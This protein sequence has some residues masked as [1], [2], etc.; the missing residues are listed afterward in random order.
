MEPLFYPLYAP[1]EWSEAAARETIR[2]WSEIFGPRKPEA[3]VSG[4]NLFQEGTRPKEVF[5]LVEGLILLTCTAPAID[6]ECILGVRFPGQVVEQCAHNLDIPYPVSAVA[7]VNSQILR[8]S[9]PALRKRE[10]ENSSTAAFFERLLSLDLYNAVLFIMELKRSLPA[11]RLKHFLNLL[12]SVMG[13]ESK[14]GKLQIAMPLHDNQI[15]NIL[16]F[17]PRQFK[18]V[19]RQLQDQGHLQVS[20]ARLWAFQ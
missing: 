6:A 2:T 1:L 14:S 15:A 5:L 9:I 8:I 11:D 20:G 4:I 12:A 7:L 16:G 19:K 17:S 10:E 3:L 18:R 13:S